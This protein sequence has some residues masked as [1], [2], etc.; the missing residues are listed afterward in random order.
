MFTKD[1]LR[2]EIEEAPGY[3]GFMRLDTIRDHNRY[4]SRC[5]NV[6]KWIE[7]VGGR[8]SGRYIVTETGRAMMH[9]LTL[10]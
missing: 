5:C 1:Q 7:R 10:T 4:L 8:K 6:K 3:D 2:S 9:H